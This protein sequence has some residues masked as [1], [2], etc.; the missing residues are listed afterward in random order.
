MKSACAKPT[1]SIAAGILLATAL[2]PAM[3]MAFE[4]GDII[5]RAGVSQVDPDESSDQLALNG[6]EQ[7]FINAV[8]PAEVSVDDNEQLGLTVGYMLTNNLQIELL[9]A[10]PFEHTVSGTDTLSGL[11]I[12]DI[13]H[14]P[15]TLSITYHFFEGSSFRPYIGAGLNYTIF[16]D[17]DITGQANAAFEG[18][19]LTGGDLELDDSWG[20]A[21]QIGA[22]YNVSGN[23]WINGSVRWID[24]GTE[25][26]IT[27]DDGTKVTTDVDIDPF[28]YSLKVAYV[29]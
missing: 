3:S 12:A 28:V 7:D 18:L 5:V 11:D 10:T 1:K 23:W 4:A 8:G 24:I 21:F 14:L 6:S 15:P 26:E 16:F 9:A 13:K 19:G 20:P 25:A 27:F 29:F 2:T 22:D 17:E